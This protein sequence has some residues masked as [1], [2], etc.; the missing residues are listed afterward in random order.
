MEQQRLDELQKIIDE[1]EKA[2]SKPDSFS[3]V[4]VL[5]RHAMEVERSLHRGTEKA[6]HF[7]HLVQGTSGRWNFFLIICIYYL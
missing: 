7:S 5:S 2:L 6:N 1:K 3:N 4:S